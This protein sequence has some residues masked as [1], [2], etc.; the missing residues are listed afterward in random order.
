ML[1]L[2]KAL[3]IFISKPR[4][5]AF[6]SGTHHGKKDG[7]PKPTSVEGEAL[8]N[9]QAWQQYALNQQA[10]SG[11]QLDKLTKALR[12]HQAAFLEHHDKKE[13]QL[14]QE[15]AG[16]NKTLMAEKIRHLNRIE[17]LNLR[18]ALEWIVQES[19][20]QQKGVPSK[21]GTPG[22]QAALAAIAKSE[23]FT[24]ILEK[25]AQDRG[26]K[27]EKVRGALAPLYSKLSGY[28]HGVD[29]PVV[30]KTRNLGP[31]E[32]AALCGGGPVESKEHRH[33]MNTILR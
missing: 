5:T 19:Q 13:Q 17:M 25:E 7:F 23:E 30:V 11:E 27:P 29:Q 1:R 22:K 31:D 21:K 28:A 16:L 24:A 32:R 26:L 2:S 4:M 20:E 18:G 8:T 9:L 33:T 3:P 10:L 14:Q 12:D 15:I 6:H